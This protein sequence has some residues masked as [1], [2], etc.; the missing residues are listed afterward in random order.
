MTSK[1]DLDIVNFDKDKI[2]CDQNYEWSLR[3]IEKSSFDR[4]WLL[5]YFWKATATYNKYWIDEKHNLIASSPVQGREAGLQFVLM[6]V[7]WD[8]ETEQDLLKF[9]TMLDIQ[10]ALVTL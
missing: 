5:S 2:N 3:N 6:I 1:F 7:S 4:F 8:C 9:K 10:T